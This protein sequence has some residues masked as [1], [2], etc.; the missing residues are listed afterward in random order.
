[1]PPPQKNM[2]VGVNV[3]MN[4]YQ[5]ADGKWNVETTYTQGG[6]APLSAQV[7][8]AGGD[9]DLTKLNDP[10]NQFN[11]ATDIQMWLDSESLLI[12]NNGEKVDFEFTDPRSAAI[13]F[14]GPNASDEFVSLTDEGSRFGLGFT[15]KD[16]RTGEYG[17]CLYVHA[18]P[19]GK[20][21]EG[22]TIPLDPNIVN[23]PNK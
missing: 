9:I 18:F 13:I 12:A 6:T 21:N 11:R 17:Y 15:D 1:M 2:E 14:S 19:K 16:D 4:G 7:V 20:P 3:F 10:N 22:W 5:D 23:R 8:D